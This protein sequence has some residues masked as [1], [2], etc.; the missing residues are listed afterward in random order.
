MRDG[1]NTSSPS[2]KVCLYRKARDSGAGD[3]LHWETYSWLNVPPTG[4][5]LEI[6]DNPPGWTVY[7]QSRFLYQVQVIPALMN[8]DGNTYYPYSIAYAYGVIPLTPQRTTPT[9]TPRFTILGPDVRIANIAYHGYGAVPK[10]AFPRIQKTTTDPIQGFALLPEQGVIHKAVDFQDQFR[11]II[12]PGATA[13][14]MSHDGEWTIIG[15]ANGTVSRIRRLETRPEFL[16]W[17]R[18]WPELADLPRVVGESLLQPVSAIAFDGWGGALIGGRGGRLLRVLPV[19]DTEDAIIVP[20]QSIISF[21]SI[22]KLES[23]I[24]GARVFASGTVSGTT[25]P[26]LFWMRFG[27]NG[28]DSNWTVGPSSFTVACGHLNDFSVPAE[29]GIV[30]AAC[31]RGL[32]VLNAETLEVIKAPSDHTKVTSVAAV[33]DGYFAYAASPLP[34]EEGSTLRL[35]GL[36]GS[37]SSVRFQPWVSSSGINAA[38]MTIHSLQALGRCSV[39]IVMGDLAKGPLVATD[40]TGF[41]KNKCSGPDVP[42]STLRWRTDG[43]GGSSVAIDMNRDGLTDIVSFRTPTW[44]LSTATAAGFNSKTLA[45]WSNAV[46][47]VDP[48]VLRSSR[49]GNRSLIARAKQTGEWWMMTIDRDG[50]PSAPQK[51]G[52]W[53]PTRTWSDVSATDFDFD[54]ADEI[55]GRDQYG[56]WF[57]GTLASNELQTMKISRWNSSVSW[58]N[59][60]PRMN[61]V[62]GLIGQVAETGEWWKMQR[63]WHNS[64]SYFSWDNSL[65][66]KWSPGVSWKDGGS[67][68]FD[69]DE[70][71]DL[72]ARASQSGEWWVTSTAPDNSQN[73]Q[74]WAKWSP[75]VAWSNVLFGDFNSD[76]KTDI[77]ARE[78]P[79]SRIWWGRSNGASFVTTFGGDVGVPGEFASLHVGRFTPLY[80]SLV[81]KKP[82]GRWINGV[83]WDGAFKWSDFGQ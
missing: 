36:D 73:T 76:G 40:A 80:N 6:P 65:L 28:N 15:F 37:E 60:F 55:V 30:Y 8:C 82:N 63:T 50:S 68:D 18:A 27:K 39:E 1:V 31:D 5:T 83:L 33:P 22:I 79:S 69:G 14:G 58:T 4:G 43:A 78:A 64:G 66:V 57:L 3:V 12:A 62:P 26:T 20:H 48:L 38:D 19:A 71:I 49:Y 72:I 42:D 51:V 13:I 61:G 52:L 74:L 24:A 75:S 45:T 77:L 34:N 56:E 25:E 2:Y 67:A 70:T 47:W 9:F 59:I 44:T 10:V 17:T 29:R 16:Q 41:P 81:M 11:S 35:L 54:E 7:P 32:F 46:T 23:D 53:S 21:S